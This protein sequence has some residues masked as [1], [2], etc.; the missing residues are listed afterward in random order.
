MR[1]TNCLSML[2]EGYANDKLFISAENDISE[3][4]PISNSLLGS[5]STVTLTES[6][7]S[8]SSLK[9]TS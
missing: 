8:I 9:G 3:S 5:L 1:T 2:L 4:I 7:K 6:Y